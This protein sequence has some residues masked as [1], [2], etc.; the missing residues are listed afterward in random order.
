MPAYIP[1]HLRKKM[2]PLKSNAKTLKKGI[3]WPSNAHGDP[4]ADVKYK[5]APINYVDKKASS[6][7]N[8]Y[9][10]IS[11]HLS[12]RKLRVKPIVTLLKGK[13]KVLKAKSL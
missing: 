6:R 4:T 12:T 3:R 13:T 11:K 5:K 2:E 10:A 9:K 1:P 8:K 7:S